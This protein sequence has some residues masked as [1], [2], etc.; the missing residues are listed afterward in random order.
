MINKIDIMRYAGRESGGCGAHGQTYPGHG[1]EDELNRGDPNEVDCHSMTTQIVSISLN[2][3]ELGL[4]TKIPLKQVSRKGQEFT[5]IRKVSSSY[6]KVAAAFPIVARN[7]GLHKVSLVSTT[8]ST[9]PTE[10]IFELDKEEDFLTF[11]HF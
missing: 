2:A 5:Y 11:L 6:L 8:D 7:I 3:K 10:Y 9:R 4:T 1:E